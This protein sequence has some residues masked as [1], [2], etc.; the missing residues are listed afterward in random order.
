MRAIIVLVPGSII[1]PF[2][3]FC[4]TSVVCAFKKAAAVSIAALQ[5][6]IGIFPNIIFADLF[7]FSVANIICTCHIAGHI[8]RTA[9]LAVAYSGPCDVCAPSLIIP[10]ANTAFAYR[11]TVVKMAASG[12]VLRFCTA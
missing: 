4:V 3:I 6:V 1:A 10:V 7:V 8:Y 5:A 11:A 9:V 12:A 2:L